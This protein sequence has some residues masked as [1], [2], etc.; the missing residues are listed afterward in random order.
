M[1]TTDNVQNA[2]PLAPVHTI[3]A[4]RIPTRLLWAMEGWCLQHDVNRSQ[5]IR[6]CIRERLRALR[7]EP[8]TGL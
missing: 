4:F 1:A 7:A 2:K 6:S 5:F 8:T 3:T